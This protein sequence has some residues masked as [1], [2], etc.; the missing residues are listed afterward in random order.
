M[1]FQIIIGKQEQK[2]IR[3]SSRVTFEKQR[4]WAKELPVLH[5][6]GRIVS[7]NQLLQ[8]VCLHFE[9]YL[10]SISSARKLSGYTKI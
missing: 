8:D 4:G 3:K 10:V 2:K 7:N 1:D 9:S 5:V 6:L